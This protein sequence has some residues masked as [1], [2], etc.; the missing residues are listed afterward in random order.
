MLYID[1]DVAIDMIHKA[2]DLDEIKN[3]TDKNE[4]VAITATSMMELYHG[5]YVM[6]YNKKFKVS[7]EK[8]KKERFA[9]GKLKDAIYQVPFDVD[10]AELSAKIFH[11]LASSGQKIEINDCMIA[12]TILTR[13]DGPLLTRNAEHFK[14]IAGLNLIS[15]KKSEVKA[16][17]P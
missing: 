13:S 15:L 5:L 6:E 12:A 2:V 11:E 17:A 14:R 16:P 9:I 8:I 10:A 7:D 1:T 3:V 4:R